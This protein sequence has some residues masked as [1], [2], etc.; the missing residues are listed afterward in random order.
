MNRAELPL[1]PRSSPHL[2]RSLFAS[3]L[4]HLAIGDDA[5]FGLPM[6]HK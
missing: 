1:A 4:T 3:F 5:S 6:R 2:A